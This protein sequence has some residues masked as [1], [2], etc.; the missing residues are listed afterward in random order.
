TQSLLYGTLS[1]G[2]SLV[3]TGGKLFGTNLG[4]LG[5]VFRAAKESRDHLFCGVIEAL[6]WCWYISAVW[7]ERCRRVFGEHQYAAGVLAEQLKEDI[8][9][10]TVARPE[11]Q[12][13]L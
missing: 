9:L 13:L 5:I 1:G 10:Y 11:F 6:I 8:R 4:F 12:L 2:G 3:L 7:K